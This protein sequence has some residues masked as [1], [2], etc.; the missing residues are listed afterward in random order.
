MAVVDDYVNSNIASELPANS[1]HMGGLVGMVQTFETAA[2]DDNGS[3]YRLFRVPTNF[4]PLIARLNNDAITGFTDAE[5]GVYKPGPGGAAV[6]IDC[7]LGTLDISAGKAD[8]NILTAIDNANLGKT[9]WELAGVS[10]DPGGDYDI[11]LTANT[12]G[13]GA[14]TVTVTIIG[15]MQ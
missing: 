2:A 7:L 9:L 10:A 6:D 13:S 14:A 5:L 4:R 8:T 11:A 3:I 12:V 15:L 1:G